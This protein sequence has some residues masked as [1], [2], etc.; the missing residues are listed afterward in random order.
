MTNITKNIM[1]AA[2][3]A[4]VSIGVA[5]AIAQKTP[6]T[7]TL[8]GSVRPMGLTDELAV[9]NNVLE[10]CEHEQDT[11]NDPEYKASIDNIVDRLSVAKA[12]YQTANGYQNVD[13]AYRNM[14]LDEMFVLLDK[15]YEPEDFVYSTDG[16]YDDV[17]HGITDHLAGGKDMTAKYT[18]GHARHFIDVLKRNNHTSTSTTVSTIES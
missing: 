7:D 13:S 15:T 14:T 3:V 16:G 4:F 6:G 11:T 10:H 5:S 8:T 2:I 1:I 18:H 9:L 17:G 12:I